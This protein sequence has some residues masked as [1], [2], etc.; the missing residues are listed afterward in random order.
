ME[1]LEFFDLLLSFDLVEPIDKYL[2]SMVEKEIEESVKYIQDPELRLKKKLELL[3][4][5]RAAKFLGENEEKVEKQEINLDL[6]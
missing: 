4:L 5:R 2:L 6:I 1:Y 3:E